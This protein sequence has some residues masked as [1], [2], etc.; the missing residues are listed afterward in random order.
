MTSNRDRRQFRRARDDAVRSAI[1]YYR[2]LIRLRCRAGE[3]VFLYGHPTGRRGRQTNVLR[4][5]LESVWNGGRGTGARPSAGSTRGGGPG[6][7]CGF[8]RCGKRLTVTAARS[9]PGW[10]LGI[11]YLRGTRVALVPLEGETVSFAPDALTYE[12]RE[13]SPGVVPTRLQRVEGLRGRVRRSID[14]ERV[15]PVNQIGGGNWQNWTK[16]T[17]RRMW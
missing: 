11:E 7:P 4:A 9:A 8:P 14:W 3:P 10:R 13:S 5:I 16:Q 6:R 12:S 1:N 2:E 17:L 15:T